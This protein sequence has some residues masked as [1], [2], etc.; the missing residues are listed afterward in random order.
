MAKQLSEIRVL[1]KRDSGGNWS[2]SVVAD[3]SSSELPEGVV[4]K[5]LSGFSVKDSD[6]LAQIKAALETEVDSK[7]VKA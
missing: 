5:A 2:I 3:V 6:T 7:I 1:L 4:E